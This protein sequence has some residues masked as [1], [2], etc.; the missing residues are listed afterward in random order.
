MKRWIAT[1]LF[2]LACGSSAGCEITASAY[3]QQEWSTDPRVFTKPDGL[4][5][6]EIKISRLTGKDAK[7]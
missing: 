5:K 3:V 7:R 1:A 2:L 6:A 4:A